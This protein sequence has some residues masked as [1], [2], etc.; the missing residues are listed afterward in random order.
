MRARQDRHQCHLL[1]TLDLVAVASDA[2][3]E[4]LLTV[5]DETAL[6]LVRT[7]GTTT[8]AVR[9]TLRATSARH[10]RDLR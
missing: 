4:P 3:L 7:I 8:V 10:T 2:D 6:H 1:R 5:A 9:T